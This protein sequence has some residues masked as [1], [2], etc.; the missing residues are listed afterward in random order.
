M[1]LALPQQTAPDSKPEEDFGPRVQRKLLQLVLDNGKTSTIAAY[2][3]AVALAVL[4]REVISPHLLL[5]WL[6]ANTVLF[7]S[8]LLAVRCY[9]R[10]QGQGDHE[11]TAPCTEVYRALV[12]ATGLVWG[13]SA[14]LLFPLY[15]E[16][17][18]VVFLIIMAGL[19]AGAVPILAPLI[20]LYY[21][22]V[23]SILLPVAA[24]LFWTGGELH[25]TLGVITLF[26]MTVLI[27]S[28]TRM[29]EALVEAFNN[30]FRNEAMVH[31][32][33]QARMAAEAANQAK[34]EFLANMS[35][36][37]RT[38][39][40]GVLGTLQLLR[41]TELASGQAELVATAHES[42]ESLLQILNDILDF[43]KIE[44][45]KLRLEQTPF[46]LRDLIENLG[47]TVA[48]LLAARGL[49]FAREV[50][51][52][53]AGPVQ[54]DPLRTRQ[55]LN[56]LL[57]NAIKF[58]DQ[59]KVTVRA[60]VTD[61]VEDDV[62]VRLEVVDTGIG[63]AE[64]DQE[65]LFQSFSQADTSLTRKYGG[66]GLGLAI[67]RQLV[68]LMDGCCGVESAPGKG[69]RFW[70]EIPF[71]LAQDVPAVEAAAPAPAVPAT[72]TALAGEVVLVEDNQ[73]NQKIAEGLLQK[74]GLTVTVAANGQEALHLLG[75]K[76]FAAVLMDCQMPV[77]DGYAATRAWREIEA[78]EGRART[79]IIAM[80]AHAMEGDREKCLAAGMDDYIS[81]PV[82]KEALSAML[83][84]WLRPA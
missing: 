69:S 67:V 39:M 36:E 49:A 19:A 62:L 4:L 16:M 50:D 42:A 55:I 73:V 33:E 2:V 30:R 44:A 77:L 10:R 11:R 84:K 65:K 37:I 57:A 66:T 9:Q 52:Q 12:V 28:A 78:R 61:R 5:A 54:G 76:R 68:H 1:A 35:H 79:P 46:R 64:A 34:N 59:G 83:E 32:L 20:R 47:Q 38:P 26:F 71:A 29:Q 41:E 25:I 23:A 53:L 3:L 6:I 21:A 75:R 72:E 80:T 70:C 58:T 60:M 40:N 7:V 74:L 81:K 43:S 56:N 18:Q 51:P 17:H 22:Y 82:K 24:V 15:A 63:I 27:N 45:G 8:R 13:A 14:P 31:S 48:P